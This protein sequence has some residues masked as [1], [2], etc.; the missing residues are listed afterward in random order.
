[1][2]VAVLNGA[3]QTID[4]FTVVLAVVF[5]FVIAIVAIIVA[6]GNDR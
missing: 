4:T 6:S 5:A 3:I 1:M 2:K